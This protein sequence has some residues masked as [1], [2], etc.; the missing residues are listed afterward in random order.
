M[1][2]H[3]KTSIH[4]EI[5][6]VWLANPLDGAIIALVK[7]SIRE[8]VPK[9]SLLSIPASEPC[10]R[11]MAIWKEKPIPVIFT[12]HR[13]QQDIANILVLAT[14]DPVLPEVGL[15]IS[16]TPVKLDINDRWFT[17]FQPC[18]VGLW[19]SVLISGFVHNQESVP[20]IDPTKLISNT[21]KF[22]RL[23][24]SACFKLG[25]NQVGV[26]NNLQ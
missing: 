14:Q 1:D 17:D 2:L 20:I 6:S 16:T 7:H 3:K 12:S 25:Q 13:F 8:Y 22:I 11:H 19:Q 5:M 18:A 21:S 24:N 26:H 9:V 23:A 4:M 10:C 15:A